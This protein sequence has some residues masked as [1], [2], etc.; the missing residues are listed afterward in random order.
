MFNFKQITAAA[1]GALISFTFVASASAAVLD[2]GN[3]ILGPPDMDVGGGGIGSVEING[4]SQE[5]RE[6]VIMGG[7]PDGI[8]TLRR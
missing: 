5:T 2:L 3:V 7:G 8:G 1:F 6:F 4:G